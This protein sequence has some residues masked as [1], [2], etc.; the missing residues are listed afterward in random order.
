[1]NIPKFGSKEEEN[2]FH[3]NKNRK[4]GFRIASCII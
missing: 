2:D 1:M 3:K 4:F